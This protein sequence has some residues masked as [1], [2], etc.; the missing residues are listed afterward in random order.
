MPYYQVKL[1]DGEKTKVEELIHRMIND[2]SEEMGKSVIDYIE[3]L[4]QEVDQ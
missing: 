1:S 3:W 4:L 2:D